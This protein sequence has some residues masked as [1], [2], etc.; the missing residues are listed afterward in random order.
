[1]PR[2]ARLEAPGATHH[3]I[4]RFV[5]RE[6]RFAAPGARDEY[7]SR[8]PKILARLDWRPLAYCVMSS[9]VHWV[10]VAGNMSS[11]AFI[12]P[13]NT[14]FGLWL[15]HRQ[16]R[17]GPVFAARH[18]SIVVDD[19]ESVPRVVSYTHNN[20]VRAKLVEDPSDSGWSSHRAYLGLEP[21]P[22]W[23]DVERGLALC[24]FDSSASGRLAFHDYVRSR[25]GLP[26]D[27]EMSGTRARELRAQVRELVGGPVELASPVRQGEML[28]HPLIHNHEAT[29]LRRWDG[30]AEHV[31][32]LVEHATGISVARMRSP[33][34]SRDVVRAR[35]LALLVWTDHLGREQQTM[36]AFLGMAV[37]SGSALLRRYPLAADELQSEARVL[38]ARCWG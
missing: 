28:R 12:H 11:S 9:H 32:I 18:T 19:G 10:M 8:V 14:G 21:A 16:D 26:R 24:G 35:R 36:S 38:A 22:P 31:A 15:N 29:L 4:S 2:Y 6:F 5:N 27:P 1:M 7:L 17:L 25:A 34:R 23:L 3:L 20:T 33:E 37:S 13:L 30:T